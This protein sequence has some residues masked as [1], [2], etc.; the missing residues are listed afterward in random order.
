RGQLEH[1]ASLLV[2]RRQAQLALAAAD[3]FQGRDHRAQA[4]RVDEA[5]ALH[6]DDDSRRAVLD[7]LRD[8]LL[9]RRRADHIEP[10]RGRDDGYAVVRGPSLEFE[11]HRRKSIWQKVATLASL[12][13]LSAAASQPSNGS[14]SWQTRSPWPG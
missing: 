4:C 7:Q 13:S 2:G 12:H 1:D 10:A 11:R 14:L 6:V 9:E 8:R 5:H 3:L